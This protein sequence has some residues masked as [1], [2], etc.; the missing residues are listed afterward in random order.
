MH[1]IVFICEAYVAVLILLFE[2]KHWPN[3]MPRLVAGG[4]V[5]KRRCLQEESVKLLAAAPVGIFLM[6]VPWKKQFH[7]F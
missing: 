6:E 4:K 3:L 7:Y 2:R 5:G 1:F